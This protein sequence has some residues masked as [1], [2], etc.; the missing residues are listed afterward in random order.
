MG[1]IELEVSRQACRFVAPT[2]G[3]EPDEPDEKITEIRGDPLSGHT[4]HNDADTGFESERPNVEQRVARA[5]AG[6]DPFAPDD[7]RGEVTRRSLAEAEEVPRGRLLLGETLVVPN[8]F[9]Y[10]R[11]STVTIP[12]KVNFVPLSGFSKEGLSGAIQADLGYLKR[13]RQ[14][15][16]EGLRHC[17][18]NGDY[19]Q[20]AGSSIV[21]PHH[22]RVTSPVPA[23]QLREV[24]AGPSLYGGITSGTCHASKRAGSVGWE[25]KE[26][27]RTLRP[28]RLQTT[29]TSAACW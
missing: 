22:Q 8:L 13:V 29:S 6:F 5:W 14:L 21:H 7:E 23:D 10:D 2:R 1:R 25:A 20:L 28:S 26:A 4:A 27:S 18:P 19:V 11:Y 16:G 15:D 9:P 3:F 24:E 17:R 12:S